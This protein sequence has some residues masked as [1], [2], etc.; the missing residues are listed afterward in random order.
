MPK[1]KQKKVTPVPLAEA[2]RSW[3]GGRTQSRAAHDLGVNVR[4]YQNWVQGRTAPQGLA[5]KVVS[6][7]VYED[8][9]S[10]EG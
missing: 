4:T 8:H 2:M 5:L 10:S 9:T 7:T 6:S 1:K 3:Q